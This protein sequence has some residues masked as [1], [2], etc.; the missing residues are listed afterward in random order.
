MASVPVMITGVLWDMFNK[1]GRPVALMGEATIQGLGVGGG[2]IVPPDQGW[3][4]GGPPHPQFPMS[5]SRTPAPAPLRPPESP[6]HDE[7]WSRAHPASE[8]ERVCW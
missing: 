5:K 2:P 3:G 7:Y 8:T 4:P 1:S 6:R